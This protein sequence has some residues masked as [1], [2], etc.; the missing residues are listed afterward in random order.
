MISSITEEVTI[1][2]VAASDEVT[3]APVAAADAVTIAPVAVSGVIET[4]TFDPPTEYTAVVDPI[5]GNDVTAAVGDANLPFQTITEAAI[6]LDSAW[7]SDPVVI[8]FARNYD[9][10]GADIGPVND[11]VTLKG[12]Y[13]NHIE[14]TPPL[15]GAG[16]GTDISLDKITC[17]IEYAEATSTVSRESGGTIRSISHSDVTI[18][19][20]GADGAAGADVTPYLQK[21]QGTTGAN[22][23]DGP[24]PTRGVKGQSLVV[25]V[26]GV[27]MASGSGGAHGREITAIGSGAFG[28]LIVRGSFRGGDGGRSG[29]GGI[30]GSTRASYT[31]VQGGTGGVGGNATSGNTQGAQGGDGGDVTGSTVVGSAGG[32]GGDGGDGGLLHLSGGATVDASPGALDFSGGDRGLVGIGGYCDL[33][34]GIPGNGGYGSGTYSGVRGQYG[35]YGLG[36]TNGGEDPP[37]A[38]RGADGSYGAYGSVGGYDY[39]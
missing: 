22:G 9:S 19:A 1:S 28:S 16:A 33:S 7:P 38:T 5:L 34:G 12:L 8:S 32:N 31:R 2:P 30:P 26:V 13:G 39:I 25:N 18:T 20:N 35:E 17:E 37:L 4:A 36:S 6:Q 14:I 27:P 11:R 24:S 23:S 21:T 10:G 29:S 15:T 3:I